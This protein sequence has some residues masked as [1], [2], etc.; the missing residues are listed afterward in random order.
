MET[1]FSVLEARPDRTMTHVYFALLVALVVALIINAGW[2][3]MAVAT[4]EHRRRVEVVNTHKVDGEYVIF[5][6]NGDVFRGRSHDNCWWY[7]GNCCRDTL[8]VIR[9]RQGGSNE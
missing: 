9:H 2:R 4:L 1:Q 5:C 3:R 7:V 6:S 8:T